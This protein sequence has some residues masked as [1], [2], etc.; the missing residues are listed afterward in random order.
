MKDLIKDLEDGRVL[1]SLLEV[2]LKVKLV[3]CSCLL[4]CP[5][6]LLYFVC[7]VTVIKGQTFCSVW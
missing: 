4:R 2:L 3:S 5:S 6:S 7:C 1:L